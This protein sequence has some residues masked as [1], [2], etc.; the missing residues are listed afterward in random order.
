MELIDI[1]EA[2][3]IKTND[4]RYFFQPADKNAEELVEKT[5]GPLAWV[6]SEEQFDEC[7]ISCEEY[8]M[9]IGYYEDGESMLGEC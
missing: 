1:K 7:V 8:G 3:F 9:C 2:R 4:G 6:L 5:I